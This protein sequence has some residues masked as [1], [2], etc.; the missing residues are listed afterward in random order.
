MAK[1][2]SLQTLA[3][4]RRERKIPQQEINE[5]TLEDLEREY[6]R[7]SGSLAARTPLRYRPILYRP[8]SWNETFITP[9]KN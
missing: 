1:P 8:V 2:K 5:K 4:N 6:I 9:I 7:K 3:R